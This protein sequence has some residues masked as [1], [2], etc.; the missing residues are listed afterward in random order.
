M[1]ISLGNIRCG[2]L[3]IELSNKL[4]GDLSVIT[5]QR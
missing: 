2:S 4:A 3:D 1:G 5:W